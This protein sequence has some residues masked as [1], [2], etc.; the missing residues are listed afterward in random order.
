[1]F[2]GW[3]WSGPF[4]SPLGWDRFEKLRRKGVLRQDLF[5]RY[6]GL[7]VFAEVK[8]CGD[9]V[10]SV[11]QWCYVDPERNLQFTKQTKAKARRRPGQVQPALTQQRLE[12]PVV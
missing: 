4:I 3:Q 11:L 1:L 2:R 9:P 10:Q 8:M 5:Q 6:A 12:E 7:A